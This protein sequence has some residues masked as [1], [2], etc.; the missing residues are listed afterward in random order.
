MVRAYLPGVIVLLIGALL[1]STAD[2]ALVSTWDGSTSVIDGTTT[3]D[4]AAHVG[5]DYDGSDLIVT[6]SNTATE[7]VVIPMQVLTAVYFDIED[8]A[9]KDPIYLYG[10]DADFV[11]RS[12]MLA[13]YSD[14][15]VKQTAVH[16]MTDTGWVLGQ[17]GEGNVGGEWAYSSAPK[18]D[19]TFPPDP[20]TYM[21]LTRTHYGIS[22]SGD[23]LPIGSS[24]RFPGDNLQGDVAINGLNY[25]IVP[26]ADVWS[27]GNGGINGRPL[28]GAGSERA[29]TPPA[30]AFTLGGWNPDWRVSQ[31]WFQWGT[32]LDEPGSPGTVVTEG[33]PT[34]SV[35][36]PASCALLACAI[37]G[38]GAML[39][40]RRGVA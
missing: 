7:D 29:V 34:P 1:C 23:L 21:G 31:V 15:P 11:R 14:T 24:L 17:D 6:L 20:G 2:A 3:Y 10:T 19:D 18:D 38:I 25:G 33:E 13:G 5:F 32:A 16:T 30:V 26:A 9:T 37:G 4:L 36:E 8:R 12:A 27:T 40:K 39:R 35:P 28:I 22:S